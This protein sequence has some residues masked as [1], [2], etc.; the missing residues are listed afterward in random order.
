MKAKKII[1]PAAIIAAAAALTAGIIVLGNSASSVTYADTLTVTAKTLED[2][3]SVNGV[4]ESAEKKN[5]YAVLNYPIETV[6]VKVGDTVKKGDVLCTLNTDELQQQIL[7][8]QA[9]VDSSGINSEYDLSEA[10]QR[11]KDALEAFEN[12]ENTAVLNAAKAVEQA[13][14]NLEDAKRQ[15]TIGKDTTIPSNLQSADSSLE[16]AKL[17]YE[18]SLKAYNDAVNALE[19][20]NYPVDVKNIY[21]ELND[22]RQRLDKVNKSSK[23]KELEDAKKKYSDAETKYND[24]NAFPEYFS[25]QELEKITS[26]YN[27]AKADYEDM[28]KKYD[29]KALQEQI[30]TQ[31]KQLAS[32]VESLE[33][34]RD[35]A[36]I[37]LDN[38]ELA[39]NSALA[40]YENALKQSDD[41]EESY[42]IAVKNAEAALEAAKNDHELA[43]RQAEAE[44]A[45]LKKAAE[46]QRT[47][48]GLNDPQVIILEDLKDKLEYAVVTAP[49]DGTV[50]AV[51]T[52]E[53]AAA[54]GVLFT[55]EN[56]DELKISAD[57]SEYNI[58]YIKS[59][60]NAVIRC[61]ALGGTE[62]EGTISSVAKT[63]S[64][65]SQS[66]TNYNIEVSIDS[67]DERLLVGMN[68]KLS[69]IS[70]QKENA[71]T[72]TYDVLTTDEKGN[73]AV[74]I[75]EKGED[76]VY[77]A[78]LVP[79]T[80]G[81]ETD[82]EIEIISD[83]IKEGMYVLTDTATITD[84]SV[85]MI[86][87][88][89]EDTE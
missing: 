37:N 35:S 67:K 57:V 2:T 34:A 61:D 64:V 13:E 7:Q 10:E 69:I 73:D 50:T 40:S 12:G 18:N 51:N 48:S 11:Y 24:A 79:V 52:E 43:V 44:L 84:G 70:E 27:S 29:K 39:Y 68:A 89:E 55:I 53:G 88:S 49:C 41:T 19:P 42:D 77:R 47:V 8:Q 20:E 22:A 38:A 86:G 54:A 71:L 30:E 1:I 16:N 9:S 36:K 26:D 21:D 59:G 76:G 17:A 25:K 46:Q 80:V 56:I 85:V 62:F 45:S 33:K 72:V 60:M 14:K 87:G 4:I 15:G 83:E 32:S 58:P 6:N 65:M 63:P 3:V 78:K 81:L 75:A 31:E 5:V 23:I 66:G 28:V 74:Y 82:Y